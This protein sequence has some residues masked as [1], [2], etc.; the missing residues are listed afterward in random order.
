MLRSPAQM[1]W[2]LDKA[3]MEHT[4]IPAIEALN[5][6]DIEERN[7]LRISLQVLY[8]EGCQ[9]SSLSLIICE[10]FCL[11]MLPFLRNASTL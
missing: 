5:R 3:T 8:G 6:N 7:S 1:M 11:G 4:A 2:D 9:L 10:I